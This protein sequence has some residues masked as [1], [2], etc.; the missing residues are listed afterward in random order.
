MQRKRDQEKVRI[1]LRRKPCG[2]SF[3]EHRKIGKEVNEALRWSKLDRCNGFTVVVVSKI[4]RRAARND[5]RFSSFEHL[6]LAAYD[7][8]QAT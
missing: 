4:V 7:D 5:G 1:A 3:G 6:R 8:P 2:V